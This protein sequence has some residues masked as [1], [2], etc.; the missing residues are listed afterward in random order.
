MAKPFRF[1]SVQFYP[2]KHTLNDFT[3]PGGVGLMIHRLRVLRGWN[4]T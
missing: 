3:W 2:F 1:G 4:I